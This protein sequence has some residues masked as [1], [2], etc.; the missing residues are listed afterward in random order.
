LCPFS[1]KKFLKDSLI[2]FDVSIILAFAKQL[3]INKKYVQSETRTAHLSAFGNCLSD[4]KIT[5][6]LS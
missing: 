5:K 4:Y 1:L 6:F 2:S 3:I